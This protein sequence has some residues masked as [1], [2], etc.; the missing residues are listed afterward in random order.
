MRIRNLE[1]KLEVAEQR[2]Q[3]AEQRA[4]DALLQKQSIQTHL[5][6]ASSSY[7]SMKSQFSRTES[8]LREALQT[9]QETEQRATESERELITEVDRLDRQLQKVLQQNRCLHTQLNEAKDA[10]HQEFNARCSFESRLLQKEDQLQAILH[11]KEEMERELEGKTKELAAHNA[12][13]WRI[14]SNKVSTLRTIG[15]GGWGEVLEGTVRV[16]VKRM[17][18][19]ILNLHNLDRLQREMRLLTEVRHPNLLQFIGAV[20]D[21]SPP[22]IITELL[23]LNLRQAYKQNYLGRGHRLTIFTDIAKALNYLHQRY[24]PIIH[25]DVSTPNILLQQMPNN[26]WKGKLSDLGSANFLQQA[27]TM[28]EGAIVY[29]PPEV[30]PQPFALDTEPPPQTVKIDV[31]SYGIVVCEVTTSQ[32]PSQE[33]YREMLQQVQRDHRLVYELIVQCTRRD[34]SDRLSMA[35]VLEGLKKIISL[36]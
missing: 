35:E 6:E 8:Q 36:Y 28:G 4:E 9:S 31:Y 22:L 20:F 24:N 15:S 25:R 1:Q 23:D 33:N 3:E 21:Q 34:P 16:A 32:F 10:E 14:P 5:V 26:G 19:A 30:I 18:F 2:A 29:S 13:V 27:Q 17:H 7:K 11:Q 12:E